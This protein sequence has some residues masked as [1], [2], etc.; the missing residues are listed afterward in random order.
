[1]ITVQLLHTVAL[2]FDGLICIAI[3]QCIIFPICTIKKL[4]VLMRQ[5]PVVSRAQQCVAYML[6]ILCDIDD[7]KQ[8]SDDRRCLE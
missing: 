7:R 2:C 4:R 3:L 5:L 8:G 6:I 1:M